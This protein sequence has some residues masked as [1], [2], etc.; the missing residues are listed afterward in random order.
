MELTT[1]THLSLITT[2]IVFLV[3]LEHLA[4]A[5]LEMFGNY[6]KQ[7]EAFDLTQTFT[8]QH[9]ARVSMA[10]QGIYNAMLGIAIIL[11]YFIFPAATLIKVWQ[12][13]MLFIIVVSVFGG[14]TATKKIFLVQT[15]P[16]VIGMLC[17]LIIK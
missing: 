10:N 3:A 7:A 4:I 11:S 8:R 13:L 17:L 1:I 15:L 16:S 6:K 14:F 2:I 9:E 5:G 12:L